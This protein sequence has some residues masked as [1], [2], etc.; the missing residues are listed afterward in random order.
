MGQRLVE[1]KLRVPSKQRLDSSIVPHVS[2]QHLQH[3]HPVSATQIVILLV[4]SLTMHV[5]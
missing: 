3:L 2:T 4:E 5:A 1:R